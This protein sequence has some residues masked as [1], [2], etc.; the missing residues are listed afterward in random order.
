MDPGIGW[1][2]KVTQFFLPMQITCCYSLSRNG[3]KTPKKNRTHSERDLDTG[4]R[5]PA[6]FGFY[7]VRGYTT[8]RRKN[9]EGYLHPLSSEHKGVS[10]R[11]RFWLRRS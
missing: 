4:D 5:T 2:T 7:K 6:I 1:G 9:I 10:R 3:K 11:M 8:H